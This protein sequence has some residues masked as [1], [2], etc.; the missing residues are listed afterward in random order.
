MESLF[1]KD[2]KDNFQII[3][4]PGAGHLIEP[5]YAPLCRKSYNKHFGKYQKNKVILTNRITKSIQNLNRGIP[6]LKKEG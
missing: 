5:P 2:K 3:S 4:Y 6:N 1:P